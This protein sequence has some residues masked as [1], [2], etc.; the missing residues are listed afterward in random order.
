MQNHTTKKKDFYMK[1][2]GNCDIHVCGDTVKLSCP[3]Q[4]VAAFVCISEQRL[5]QAIGEMFLNRNTP[6][7]KYTDM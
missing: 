1:S 7:L 3:I 5:F 4:C 2:I 6:T